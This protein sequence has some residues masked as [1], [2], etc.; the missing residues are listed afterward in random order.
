MYEF[1][2]GLLALL[3]HYYYHYYKGLLQPCSGGSGMIICRGR[4]DRIRRSDQK[5]EGTTRDLKGLPLPV[6]LTNV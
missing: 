4:G 3:I 2:K 5:L 1:Y 6:H